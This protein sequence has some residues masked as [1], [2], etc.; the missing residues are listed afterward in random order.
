MDHCVAIGAEGR[1]AEGHGYAVIAAGIYLSAV[2]RLAAG[3]VEA[4]VE[5]R[6]FCAHRAEIFCD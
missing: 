3:N 2:E 5:L 1:D 6:D 4:I